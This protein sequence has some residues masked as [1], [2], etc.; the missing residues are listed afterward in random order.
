[1]F[2]PTTFKAPL[3]A[4]TQLAQNNAIATN[5][6][7]GSTKLWC[8]RCRVAIKSNNTLAYAK[9]EVTGWFQLIGTKGKDQENEYIL[10]MY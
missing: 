6:L 4:A 5:K 2:F 3:S 7:D 10:M 8:I 1:M 9:F